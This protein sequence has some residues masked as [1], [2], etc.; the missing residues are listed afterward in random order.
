MWITIALTG[1]DC[2]E[3]DDVQ[4]SPKWLP[5]NFSLQFTKYLKTAS[6]YLLYITPYA[7]YSYALNSLGLNVC[8]FLCLLTRIH[9]HGVTYADAVRWRVMNHV[10][11]YAS[12]CRFAAGKGGCPV[13]KEIA[14]HYHNLYSSNVGVTTALMVSSQP[15]TMDVWLKSRS[16][17]D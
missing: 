17:V 8:L 6:S 3:Y 16:L 15:R 10:Q 7:E 14:I 13:V 1:G 4:F 9:R 5:S 11:T 2:G 12:F